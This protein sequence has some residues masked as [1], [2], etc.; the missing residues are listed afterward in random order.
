MHLCVS[1][2][3]FMC[4]GV[5]GIYNMFDLVLYKLYSCKTDNAQI[6]YSNFIIEIKKVVLGHI[7]LIIQLYMHINIVESWSLTSD[8]C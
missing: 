2:C 6:L 5:N 4:V 8:C 3:V 1:V 7:I